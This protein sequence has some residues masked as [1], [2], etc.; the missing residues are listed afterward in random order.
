MALSH[1][2]IGIFDLKQNDMGVLVMI[3]VFIVVYYICN[4]VIIWIYISEVAVDTALSI[5]VLFI[6]GIVVLL[7]LTT[8]FL[9]Q[10]ALHTYGVFF[11]FGACSMLG[12]LFCFVFV[13]ETTGLN[14]IEKKRLY[15]KK[16]PLE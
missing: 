9:M 2:L 1:F 4:G 12:S 3:N 11:L 7:S 14:D 13:K 6:W 16:A 5:A 10:S 8:N 15:M